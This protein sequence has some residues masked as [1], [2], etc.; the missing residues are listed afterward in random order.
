MKHVL[1]FGALLS[2]LSIVLALSMPVLT[3]CDRLQPALGMLSPSQ[4]FVTTPNLVQLRVNQ[5]V[6][7]K[8]IAP[9]PNM[10]DRP[11]TWVSSDPAIARVS[12]GNVEALKEGVVSINAYIEGIPNFQGCVAFITNEPVSLADAFVATYANKQVNLAWVVPGILRSSEVMVRRSRTSYPDSKAAGEL[13][14][15]GTATTFED[16]AIQE[17]T[18]YYYSLFIKSGL[19]GWAGPATCTVEI[20][21]YNS[22]INP[23][24]APDPEPLVT[25]SIYDLQIVQ[26]SGNRFLL[27]W[28]NPTLP[29]VQNIVQKGTASFPA[30]IEVGTRVG[31]YKANVTAVIDNFYQPG[32]YYFSIFTEYRSA[33]ND[34]LY[35]APVKVQVMVK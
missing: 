11:V 19:F 34:V 21:G 13:V 14:Y 25:Q 29:F 31:S 4:F 26:V 8:L 5:S 33:N 28:K 12:R 1:P 15:Q 22:V 20:P 27:T 3:G 10:H 16:C 30:G 32:T 7:I 35:T 9:N 6:Q 18:H 23:N 17:K 24:P 2:V